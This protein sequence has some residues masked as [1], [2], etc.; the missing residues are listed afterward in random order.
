[1]YLYSCNFNWDNH[2]EYVYISDYFV[3]YFSNTKKLQRALDIKCERKL[4]YVYFMHGKIL[5]VNLKGM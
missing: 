5:V 1:M 3:D 4:Y 2:I